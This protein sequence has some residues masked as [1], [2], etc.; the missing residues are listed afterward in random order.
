MFNLFIGY[1]PINTNKVHI[2]YKHEID[3]SPINKLNIYSAIRQHSSMTHFFYNCESF[4]LYDDQLTNKPGVSIQLHMCI[5][6][7]LFLTPHLLH[8]F[9][10]FR[11]F[12]FFP[13][14][15]V[16]VN[17]CT[18][19][20]TLCS[21]FIIFMCKLIHSPSH[22]MINCLHNVQRWYE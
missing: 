20:F 15:V 21:I 9:D 7:S 13:C 16:C 5:L 18:I 22:S 1:L 3:K 2:M 17:Y 11:S 4:L 14:Y 8:D 19:L 12:S 10:L 6:H